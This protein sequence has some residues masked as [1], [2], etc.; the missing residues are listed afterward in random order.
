[1]NWIRSPLGNSPFYGYYHA[2]L[3]PKNLADMM[4]F[5]PT[6]SY[7]YMNEYPNCVHW[8]NCTGMLLC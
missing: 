1:M 8:A 6:D 2:I 4:L 5:T 3:R 7:H